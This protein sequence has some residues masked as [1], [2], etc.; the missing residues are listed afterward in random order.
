MRETRD[1][2]SSGSERVNLEKVTAMHKTVNR[3]NQASYGPQMLEELTLDK[4]GSGRLS[5]R[6]A[7]RQQSRYLTLTKGIEDYLPFTVQV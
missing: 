4:L 5:F 1:R 2:F 6:E 7:L 3:T